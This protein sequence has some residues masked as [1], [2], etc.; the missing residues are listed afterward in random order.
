MSPRGTTNVVVRRAREV[1]N[2]IRRVLSVSGVSSQ[3]FGLSLMGLSVGRILCSYF[4]SLS[5]IRRVGNVD[6]IPR[7]PSRR[8]CIGYSR[9]RVTETF[10]GVVVGNLGCSG[11]GVAITY[12]AGRGCI[13]V[14]FGSSNGNVGHSSVRRVFSEFCGNDS[15]KANVNL[16]LTGR[17]VRLRGNDMATCGC[18]SNTMFRIGLPV[19]SWLFIRVTRGAGGH[20][21]IAFL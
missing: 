11:G 13:C 19:V 12:R 8:V 6:V 18:L 1:A 16:S 15:N 4:Q 5:T 20:L 7:F 17:V 2:L 3:R 9:S 21:L 10:Q 14:Q